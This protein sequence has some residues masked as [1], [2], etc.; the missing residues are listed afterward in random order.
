V[1]PFHPIRGRARAADEISGW[2]ELIPGA[3]G[4][5]PDAGLGAGLGELGELGEESGLI[6]ISL[7]S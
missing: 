3:G 4:Y 1:S 6:T 7:A 5:E 2:I